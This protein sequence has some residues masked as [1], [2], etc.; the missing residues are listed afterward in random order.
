MHT[1]AHTHTH[2]HIHTLTH[3][4]TH[5]HTQRELVFYKC[6]LNLPPSVIFPLLPLHIFSYLLP[7]RNDVR[8]C[9]PGSTSAQVHDLKHLGVVADT[10][11]MKQL[12]HEFKKATGKD[13][14][15]LKARVMELQQDIVSSFKKVTDYGER[16]KTKL[17][18]ETAK[19]KAKAK[20]NE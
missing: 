5:T 13:K 2:I 7:R 6:L 8:F 4:L 10:K 19:E 3:S 16:A 11:K 12:V 18:R 17:S 20:A 9:R 1:H 15:K 14:A